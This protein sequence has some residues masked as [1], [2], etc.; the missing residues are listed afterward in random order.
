MSISTRYSIQNTLV[1]K[2]PL[3][4]VLLTVLLFDSAYSYLAS[5][6]G[7]MFWDPR[8]K[9]GLLDWKIAP[10]TGKVTFWRTTKP[11]LHTPASTFA[12]YRTSRSFLKIR[13]SREIYKHSF[14]SHLGQR[15]GRFMVIHT[16]YDIYS[17]VS[18]LFIYFDIETKDNFH[19]T[20]KITTLL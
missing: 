11:H 8:R 19:Q 2:G 12:V 14:S 16:L 13:P 15:L 10:E 18:S 1:R 5:S 3:L 20:N 9:P 17:F 7:D 6:W 4:C